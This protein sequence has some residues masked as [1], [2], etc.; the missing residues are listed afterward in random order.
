MI[1]QLDCLIFL[2]HPVKESHGRVSISN[3]TRPVYVQSI[4]VPSILVWDWRYVQWNFVVQTSGKK[5]HM[6]SE[7]HLTDLFEHLQMQ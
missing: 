1:R 2:D 4:Y 5:I 7:P 3:E 6:R